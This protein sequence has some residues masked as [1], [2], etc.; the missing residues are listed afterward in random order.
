MYNRKV[1]LSTYTF[2]LRSSNI[3]VCWLA[4]KRIVD[5]RTIFL[6]C[7]SIYVFH[8]FSYYFIPHGRIIPSSYDDVSLTWWGSWL[9][10][11]VIQIWCLALSGY[12]SSKEGGIELISKLRKPSNFFLK[13]LCRRWPN[14]YWGFKIVNCLSSVN[15]ILE[16]HPCLSKECRV[17]LMPI[18]TESWHWDLSIEQMMTMKLSSHLKV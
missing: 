4:T 15:L 5:E 17:S 18:T 10:I 13:Y 11:R 12:P 16:M 6:V 8:N 3:R 14:F 1:N 7:A 9:L 2:I